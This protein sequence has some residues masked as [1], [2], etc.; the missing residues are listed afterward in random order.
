VPD[1]LPG[2]HPEALGAK[3]LSQ[4]ITDALARQVAE[5]PDALL[6]RFLRRG[7]V[8]AQCTFREAWHL[9]ERWAH[10][11]LRRGVH[12][13]EPVLLCLPNSL[14]FVGAYFGAMLAGAAPAPIAPLRRG[15]RREEHDSQI[16]AQ[17]VASASARI[18]VVPAGRADVAGDLSQSAGAP[19][20]LTSQDL[21]AVDTALGPSLPE[22]FPEGTAMLQFTSGTSSDAKVVELT[23]RALLA[24]VRGIAGAIGLTTTSGDSAVSWL[25]LFHD[26]GLIGFLLTPALHGCTV[27]FLRNEDLVH[28]IK[29]AS[30][31]R[32]TIIGGPPSAYALCARYAKDTAVDDF[33]LRAVRVAL[34]GAE[35]I[36]SHSLDLFAEKFS[37]AGFARRSLAPAYGLAEN[38]LAVTMTSQDEGVRLDEILLAPLQRDG[39]AVAVGRHTRSPSVTRTVVAVGRPIS[40]TEV[41]LR[42]PDGATLGDRVVGEIVVRSPSLMKCY[43]GN[44]NATA[45]ALREGWLWTGDLGYTADGSLY[46]T[47]RRKEVLIVAGRN[48][49]P[50]DLEQIVDS[51]PGI[52]PGRAVAISCEDTERFTDS[53]IVLAET[54]HREKAERVSLRQRIRESLTQA[55]F[56]CSDVFLLDYQ[57]I[58]TTSSGKLKRLDLRT[59]YLAGEFVH[60]D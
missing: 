13:A 27:T 5:R 42:G 6:A 57:T 23:H 37:R 58:A 18:L 2:E 19:A 44:P 41:T 33:D 26:M 15:K 60:D 48:Y 16:L 29:A 50:E 22:A 53:V 30:D 43:R 24:Q 34:V 9:A 45:Q 54:S 39:L 17:R 36:A 11:F 1:G 56:P 47:G 20:V 35:M 31:Y 59:R 52:Y 14:D 4:T 38:G 32:A 8:E 10:A 46:V 55:N 49:Y 12:K 3:P 21:G 28:W 40:N 7:E 25:P 51:I